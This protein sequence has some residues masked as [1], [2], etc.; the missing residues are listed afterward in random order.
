MSIFFSFVLTT[1]LVLLIIKYKQIRQKNEQLYRRNAELVAAERQQS[2]KPK[3]AKRSLGENI[4]VELMSKIRQVMESSDEIFTVDFS[5][6]R[7]A[8]LCETDQNHISQVINELC[9]CNYNAL[10][11]EH[12]IREAC[13]RISDKAT[14]GNYTIEAIGES[15][16]IKSR[17]HF[18]KL[19]KEQTGLTPSTYMKMARKQS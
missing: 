16:G 18:V 8:E 14:Y 3:Y 12:S 15:V 6:G 4:K 9:N 1:L 17:S 2:D 7:L 5:Q 19:F 13:R 11:N 10:L